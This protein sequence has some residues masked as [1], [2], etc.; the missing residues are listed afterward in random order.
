MAGLFKG[1]FIFQILVKG[2]LFI[3]ENFLFGKR[4][5]G[6]CLSG[7]RVGSN[8]PRRCTRPRGGTWA[9]RFIDANIGFPLLGE[10]LEVFIVSLLTL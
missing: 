4:G 2:L 6:S 7:G 8:R 3:G 5:W 1:S 9:R 10:L